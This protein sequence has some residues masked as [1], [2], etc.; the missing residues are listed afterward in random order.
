M[1]G[2]NLVSFIF[3]FVLFCFF[4]GNFTHI[5]FSVFCAVLAAHVHKYSCSIL[6][7]HLEGVICEND[8][9]KKATHVAEIELAPGVLDWYFWMQQAKQEIIE[10]IFLFHIACT[11]S[12]I[13]LQV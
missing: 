2:Q 9:V 4:V 13:T 1:R 7:C 5:Y 12:N 8:T 6:Y 10:N 3:N 11:A